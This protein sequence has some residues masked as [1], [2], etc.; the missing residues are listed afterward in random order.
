MNKVH[1]SVDESACFSSLISFNYS[2][3]HF[4][5]HFIGQSVLGTKMLT[6]H[7][8]VMIQKQWDATFA[9]GKTKNLGL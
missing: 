8:V 9:E 5:K 4:F 7:S 2:V 1:D 6:G 3:A